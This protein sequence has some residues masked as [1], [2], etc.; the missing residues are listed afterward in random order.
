[1]AHPHVINPLE[2]RAYARET[3]P[4]VIK[5]VDAL[6]TFMTKVLGSRVLFLIALVLPLLSLLPALS[7]S[8]RFIL[9]VSS[10]WIQWWALHALQRSQNQSDALH[11]AKA[12]TD[13][14]ALTHI[15]TQVDA[16]LG[17]EVPGV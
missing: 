10:T 3:R 14:A 15:A 13:H 16:L 8:Q 17:K 5:W 12:Q 6:L 9:I 11:E 7:W 2:L 1:M 4:T